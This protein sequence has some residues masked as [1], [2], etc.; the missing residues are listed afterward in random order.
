MSNNV[1]DHSIQRAQSDV[2]GWLDG[3]EDLQ[4]TSNSYRG[5]MSR[6]MTP[7]SASHANTNVDK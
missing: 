4:A 1:F 3:L 7:N 6:N 5:S 2:R